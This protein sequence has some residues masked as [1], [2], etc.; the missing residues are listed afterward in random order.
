M[1]GR[2]KASEAAQVFADKGGSL[3]IRK[4]VIDRMVKEILCGNQQSS[5]APAEAV[6][7]DAAIRNL[8]QWYQSF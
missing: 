6:G 3:N 5:R 7:R 8:R 4:P 1:A 2:A